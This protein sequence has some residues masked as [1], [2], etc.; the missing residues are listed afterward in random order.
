[1]NIDEY[2]SLL[3]LRRGASV[4]EIKKAYRVKALQFHP[5]RNNDPGANTMFIRITEAYQYLISAPVQNRVS[6]QERER[7]YAAWVEYRREEA[8]SNAERYAR[9]SYAQFR[10]SDLY[11][12]TSNIDIRIVRFGFGLSLVIIVYTIYGYFYRVSIATCQNEMPSLLLMVLSLSIG[13]VFLAITIL[14]YLAWKADKKKQM[15][16]KT[17]K[18]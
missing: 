13:I 7:Y 5:D 8:K 17:S 4:A 6:D 3:G 15:D 16:G 10:N 9:E 11:K 18:Q 2:Y 12:S 1:M 14:H